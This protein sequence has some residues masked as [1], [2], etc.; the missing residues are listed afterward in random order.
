M[1]R[2]PKVWSFETADY[3]VQRID[4]GQF[5]IEFK[6]P[7]QDQDLILYMHGDKWKT[8]NFYKGSK[9]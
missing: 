6:A 4:D 1:D 3:I 9:L 7:I 8:F 2:V 5:E